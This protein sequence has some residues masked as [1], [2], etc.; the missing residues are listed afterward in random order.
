MALGR[1]ILFYGTALIISAY[2]LVVGLIEAKSFLAPLVTAVV[3]ALLLLPVSRKFEKWGMKRIYA[4]LVN[5]FL[6]FL[7]SLGFAALISLQLSQFLNDWDKAKQKITPKIEQLEQ[8]IQKN[9][10]ID[11]K[12][13]KLSDNMSSGNVGKRALSFVNAFYS[14]AADFLLTFIYIFFLLNYRRKL[15][16]FFLRLFPDEREGEVDEVLGQTADITQDYLLGKFILMIILAVLYAVGM[17]ISGVNNFIVVSIL[18]SLLS[19][20]P[21]IGNIIG[22]VLAVGLGYI[23]TGE[24]GVLIGIVVTFTIAQ[25]IESYVLEPYIVGDKVNLD[26]FITIVAVVLGNI[27]WGVIGMILALPILAVINLIFAH[28][29]PLKPF[30]FLLSNNSEKGN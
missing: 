3:F 21:Y 26:P 5:T 15:R 10:P 27:L 16:R 20:I 30:N 8:L 7:L 17:G 25:F 22:F 18:A 1:K 23:T 24:T 12:D 14:F 9:T 28:V 6:L 2:F 19:I 11:K 29:K 13:L 4:S